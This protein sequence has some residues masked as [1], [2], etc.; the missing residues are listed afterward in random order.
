MESFEHETAG[1]EDFFANAV[2]RDEALGERIVNNQ[3]QFLKRRRGGNGVGWWGKL[4]MRR[5]RAAVDMLM[6]I[7]FEWVGWGISRPSEYWALALEKTPSSSIA[8]G[9]L[10]H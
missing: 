4:P 10:K 5:A 6:T 1:G 7:L 9:S 3:L 2:T 8:F